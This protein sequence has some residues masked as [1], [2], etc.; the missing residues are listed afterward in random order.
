MPRSKSDKSKEG[1]VRRPSKPEYER[2]R[3]ASSPQGHKF[4]VGPKKGVYSYKDGKYTLMRNK[5]KR[6]T[7][8][9]SYRVQNRTD[10]R[11]KEYKPI[12]ADLRHHRDNDLDEVWYP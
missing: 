12:D 11:I 2:I 6:K 1:K 7:L 10:D 3:G 5:D 9:N 8:L 4:Y